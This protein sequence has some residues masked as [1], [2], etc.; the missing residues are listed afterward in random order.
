M[1]FLEHFKKKCENISNINFNYEYIQLF[2][3]KFNWLKSMYQ[4]KL[5]YEKQSM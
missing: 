5:K 2:K 3:F 1:K 4:K